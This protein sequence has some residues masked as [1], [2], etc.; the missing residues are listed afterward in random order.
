M[1][2]VHV[3]S[4]GRSILLLSLKPKQLKP[5]ETK[6]TGFCSY[7]LLIPKSSNPQKLFVQLFIKHFK[8]KI[9]E[10]LSFETVWFVVVMVAVVVDDYPLTVAE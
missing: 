2:H 10:Q 5:V 4:L 3:H 1:A 6:L 7:L 9:G 8:R